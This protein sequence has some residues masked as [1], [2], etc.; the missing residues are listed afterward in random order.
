MSLCSNP[1][2]LQSHL[3]FISQFLPPFPLGVR[4]LS[5]EREATIPA[6]PA[7][8]TALIALSAH[9]AIA[10]LLFLGRLLVLVCWQL[11]HNTGEKWNYAANISDVVDLALL[12]SERATS[13][14][15]KEMHMN[16][17]IRLHR[18]CAYTIYIHTYAN[19]EK[20]HLYIYLYI[21]ICAYTYIYIYKYMHI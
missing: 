10:C 17:W 14:S 2:I 11:S 7:H 15:W 21:H 8:N 16:P 1:T 13:R 5:R 18:E 12:S 9:S 6:I 4:A 20:I 19:T 3:S